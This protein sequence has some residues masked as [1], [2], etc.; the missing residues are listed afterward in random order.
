M[1]KLGEDGRAVAEHL[2]AAA[3]SHSH[4]C[5]RESA[6]IVHSVSCNGGGTRVTASRLGHV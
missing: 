4:L 1:H 5:H 3:L 6:S 2:I